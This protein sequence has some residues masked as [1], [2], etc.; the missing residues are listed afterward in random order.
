MGKSATRAKQRYNEK[1]YDDI[2]LRV[3]KGDKQKYQL[4]AD[5]E[6]MSLNAWIIKKMNS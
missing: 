4:L 2:R 3:P 6:G 5:L 1:A